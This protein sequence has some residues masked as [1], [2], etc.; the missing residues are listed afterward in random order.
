MIA[1]LERYDSDTHVSTTET[2]DLSTVE[3][4]E[5]FCRC[6]QAIKDLQTWGAFCKRMESGEID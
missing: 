4:M 6:M 3:G 5:R 2:V 1:N